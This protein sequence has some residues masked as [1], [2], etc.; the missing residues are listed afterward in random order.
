MKRLAALAF[1][2]ALVSA[3]AHAHIMVSPPQSKSGAVQ[4]Y[5]LRAHNEAKLATTMLEL[6]VPE[7]ITI[8][9]VAA[10]ASGTFETT[11]AGDRITK[12]TWKVEVPAGKYLA[13]K[14]TAKNPDG[15][16]EVHWNVRQHMADGSV[17]DWSDKPG[18]KEKASVTKISGTTASA[19]VEP[20]HHDK[21]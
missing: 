13:L 18:A 12:V 4:N 2:F 11:K 16:R 21:G 6:D 8:Q 1:A 10:P 19:G 17:V 20:E 3:T 9:E 14:F 5:E 15:E 7:G